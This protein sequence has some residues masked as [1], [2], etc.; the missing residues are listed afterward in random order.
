MI[1][2]KTLQELFA[3]E[4]DENKEFVS[5][6]SLNEELNDIISDFDIKEYDSYEEAVNQFRNRI[7]KLR[8]KL[9]NKDGKELKDENS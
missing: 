4:V 6:E 7:I 5:V 3:E 2:K 8:N 1:E 9:K